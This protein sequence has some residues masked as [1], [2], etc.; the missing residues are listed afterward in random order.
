MR[1]SISHHICMAMLRILVQLK[2]GQTVNFRLKNACIVLIYIFTYFSA[3]TYLRYTTTGVYRWRILYLGFVLGIDALCII[4]KL[5]RRVIII[6]RLLIVLATIVLFELCVSYFSG[7][8]VVP[9]IFVDVVAWPMILSV[10]YDYSKENPIPEVFKKI[11]FIGMMLICLFT[12]P[13]VR[14]RL[15][16]AGSAAVFATYYCMT[17]L[18]M[19]LMFYKDRGA[20]IFS[21]IVLL[22]MLITLKRSAF[23]IVVT[24]LFLYYV[25]LVSNQENSKKKLR[26]AGGLAIGILFFILAGQYLIKR[27]NLNI[28][29]RLSRIM[30]DGGSGRTRIWAQVMYYFNNSSLIEKWIGHGFHAVFYEIR[31]LG[32]ARY[33]HNSFLETLYDYGYIGLALVVIVV[34]KITFDTIRMIHHHDELAPLMA[35]SLVPM[36]ILG[37]VSYFFEQAVMILPLCILW[38]ICMGSYYGKS[39]QRG[40]LK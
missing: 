10:Y 21:G 23:I 8:F 1:Q 29:D 9:M 40:I 33:A 4:Y 30:D 28:L 27:M 37:F 36:Y 14:L 16:G 32:I 19:I 3:L 6:D 17:F 13:A 39:T 25:I 5:H 20:V 11:T 2:R 26:R 18:P 38:G 15:S 35:Y 12:I 7:L 31:P 24:G 22:L 34:L